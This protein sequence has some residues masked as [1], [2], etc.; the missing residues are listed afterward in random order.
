MAF[1]SVHTPAIKESK[2]E[3]DYLKQPQLQSYQAQNMMVLEV[4]GNPDVALPESFRKLFGAY[5]KLKKIYPDLKTVSPRM[6]WLNSFD[7]PRKDW[8]GIYGLP[9]PDSITEL[10]ESIEGIKLDR[11]EYGLTAEILH[12]GSLDRE[13]FTVKKL[14]NLIKRRGFEI[15]GPHEEEYLKG[16]AIFFRGDPREYRTIIRYRLKKK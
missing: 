12:I 11:W 6:R 16:P 14:T 8:L 13:I 15:S 1:F 5:Y 7:T 3:Y 9:L 4:R 10:P 2:D